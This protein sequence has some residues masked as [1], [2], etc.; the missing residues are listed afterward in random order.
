MMKAARHSM[1]VVAT[2]VL[3]LLAVAAVAMADER[4][5]KD[6]A[7][8]MVTAAVD[9]V[10]KVGPEQAFKDFTADK[11]RWTKKDLY[12]VAIDMKGNM[13]A[14]G[15]NP[16]LIGKNMMEMKDANGV[17]FT[18]E[19][20]KV[21]QTR[22][23]GWVDYLWPHPETRKMAGKSTYVRKLA[24]YDGWVGVGIYR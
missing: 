19:M 24:N 18:A 23:E 20:T 2:A 16:K 21:A 14:H 12:V 6:E 11:A 7:M 5:T 9:H 1:I 10:K 8:A 13:L 3:S 4:G 22:G 15:A 17:F